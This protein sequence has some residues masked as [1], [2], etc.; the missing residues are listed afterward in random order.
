[1]KKLIFRLPILLLLLLLAQLAKSQDI[2]VS[3]SESDVLSSTIRMHKIIGHDKAHY[4]VIHSSGN[5][6]LIQKRDNDLNFMEEKPIKLFKGLV[7]YNLEAVYHFHQE[8][9]VFVTQYRFND[10]VLFYQKIDKT[11]LLPA[12]ELIEIT[13]IKNVKGNWADFH[14]ALSRDES[15]LL[16]AC[17]IK[18]VWSGAQLNEYYVFGENLEMVWRRKDSFNFKGQGPR[19]NRYLVDD[20]GNVTVIS[21]IKRE[22]LLSLLSDVKNVFAIYRYTHDGVD[23]VE[24]PI[25]L[26]EKYIRGIKIIGGN[27]GDMICAGLYSDLL[28]SGIRGTFYFRIDSE[29]GQITDNYLNEF[30]DAVMAELSSMNEPV[31]NDAELISYVISDM[32]LRNDNRVIIIAE[33]VFEQSYNTYNNLIVTSYDIHGQVYWTRIIRKRQDFNYSSIVPTGIALDDYRSYIRDSGY[34]N[35]FISNYCSYALMAPLDKSQIVIVYND[36]IKNRDL[37]VSEKPFSLPRKSYLVAVSVDEFGNITR[38]PLVEWKKRAL[39]PEPMRYYDTLGDEVIIPGF[40]NRKINFNKIT[41]V[42]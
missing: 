37:P 14:F 31:I 24:Y 29:T 28:R 18:L 40:R 2:S 32:V 13:T 20:T 3:T 42:F 35:S 21:L 34:M 12:T 15:K 1:M 39:F 19:D 23:F 41:A 10:V 27:N 5:Q 4:Y 6:Y 9:Y 36:D 7:T 30:D 33:Q 17:R 11:T 26:P 25:T 16:V 8:I 22:S 38:K